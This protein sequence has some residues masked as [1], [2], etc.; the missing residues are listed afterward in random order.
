MGLNAMDKF[1]GEQRTSHNINIIAKKN[2]M[3]IKI[4]E[5]NNKWPPFWAP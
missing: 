4:M 5:K 3:N 2:Y 1:P